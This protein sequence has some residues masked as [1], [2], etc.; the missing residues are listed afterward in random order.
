MA[1]DL[2]VFI[3]QPDSCP[4]RRRKNFLSVLS[5]PAFPVS[6]ALIPQPGVTNRAVVDSEVDPTYIYI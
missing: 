5:N 1:G 6:G 2:P 3:Y 4:E